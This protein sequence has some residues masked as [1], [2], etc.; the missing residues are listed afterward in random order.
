V[1]DLTVLRPP[2]HVDTAAWMRGRGLIELA[3]AT[4][5]VARRYGVGG[6]GI[7]PATSAV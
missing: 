5:T 3:L 2:L 4:A 7:E 1:V 6:T